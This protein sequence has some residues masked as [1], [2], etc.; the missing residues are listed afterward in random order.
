ML[1]A[2]SVAYARESLTVALWDEILPL[3]QA[4]YHEVAHFKDLALNPDLATYERVQAT[5]GLRIYTARL[6]DNSLVGY[7]VAFVARSMH[8]ADHIFANQDILFVSEEHRGSR[9]GVDLIKYAHSRLRADDHVSV[10]MQHCKAKSELNIGPM[11]ER[12]LKYELVDHI[13]AI[14]LDQE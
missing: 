2:K 4:H 3:L 12:L 5:G 11:L 8:Y 14:R 6:A 9:I 7:M 1:T 10:C 13:Y